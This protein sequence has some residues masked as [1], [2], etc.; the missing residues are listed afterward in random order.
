MFTGPISSLFCEQL[1]EVLQKQIKVFGPVMYATVDLNRDR[2]ARTRRVDRNQGRAQWN[3]SFHIYC[4]HFSTNVVFSIKLWL[5]IN[6]I[7]IGR[8]SLPVRDI[9]G[10]QEVDRWLDM[11]NE[12]KQLPGGPRI[13]VRIKF[14]HVTKDRNNG[15]GEGIGNAQYPGV[16]HTFFKQRPGCKVTLYQDAHMLNTFNQKI[17][18]AGGLPYEPKRSWEDIYDAINNARHLVYITGWSVYT[19]V[20][21]VRDG[22]R[23]HPGSGITIGELLKRKAREGVRV[24]MMIWDDL[25][26]PFNLGIKEGLFGTHDAKTA[27]YFRFSD[28]HYVLCPRNPDASQ[29]LLQAKE[30]AYMMCHHQK[31]VIVDFDMKDGGLVALLPLLEALTFVMAAMTHKTTPSS[32]HSTQCI[33]RTSTKETL[34]VHPLRRVG[35]ES[36]GMTSIQRSKALLLGMCFT[37]LNRGG[38]SKAAKMSLSIL[39]VWKT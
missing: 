15:W 5:P 28:V 35:Q 24:L 3:E 9:L 20:T 37:T 29:S 27:N 26:T 12:E 14:T 39:K 19:E 18:L 23:Q 36:H 22:S 33:V 32:G 11:L 17:S 4:A 6:A 7:L 31:S 38:G 21:L 34:K 10:G 30:T 13:H 25:T 16:P 2:V 8:A 1:D